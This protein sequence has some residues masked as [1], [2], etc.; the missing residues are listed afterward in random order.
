MN[1]TTSSITI[2][3]EID[4]ILTLC[5]TPKTFHEV[6]RITGID[7]NHLA[8]VVTRLCETNLLKKRGIGG[9]ALYYV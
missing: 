2:V 6:W 8:D 3:N 5:S 1:Y 4:S 7:H 9:Q